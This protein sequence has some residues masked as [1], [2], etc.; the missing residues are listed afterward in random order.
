MS[1]GV[2]VLI[3]L[4]ALLLAALLYWAFVITEGAYLGAHVVAWTYDLTARRYDAIKRFNLVDD[5]WLL[6]GPMA[7]ALRHVHAPL[8]LDVATGTARMPLALLHDDR[9]RGSIV[10]LDLSRKM[11][12]QAEH[13]LRPY[14]GRYALIRRDAGDLPFPDETF[15]AVSCLEA[16]EFMP[17]PVRVLGEMARVLRPGGILLTTNRVNWERRLMPGKAFSDDQLRAILS[18]VGLETIEIRAWQVY[19]DLLWA[20]KP[21]A[22]SRLG[23]GVREWTAIV[24]CPRCRATP[25]IDATSTYRCP[26]CQSTFSRSQGIIDLA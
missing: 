21:G 8:I 14:A 13:K 6:A 12:R 25:L 3:A 9:F 20:R 1:A 22:P 24:R 10:A 15:D 17:D 19:Y 23:H 5:V 18:Q 7:H 2:W 4:G 11:L 16:L 26:S